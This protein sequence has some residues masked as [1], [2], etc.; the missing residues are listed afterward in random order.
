MRG[1]RSAWTIVPT[2]I[3]P[4]NRSILRRFKTKSFYHREVLS[5]SRH[6]RQASLNCCCS[7]KRVENL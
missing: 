4:H 5:I 3:L 7:Y 1:Q 6:Q 2:A